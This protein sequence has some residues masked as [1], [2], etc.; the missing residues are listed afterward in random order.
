[1]TFNIS[2]Q[3]SSRRSRD[4]WIGLYDET[5]AFV[6]GC[7]PFAHYAGLKWLAKDNNAGQRDFL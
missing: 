1:M 5:G 2:S 6:I 7:E 3:R 4:V